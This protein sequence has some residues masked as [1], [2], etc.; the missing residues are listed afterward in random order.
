MSMTE[1]ALRR[2]A[3]TTPSRETSSMRLLASGLHFST[4]P[5]DL[6]KNA[7]STAIEYCCCLPVRTFDGDLASSPSCST[8]RGDSGRTTA[9]AWTPT[10]S[11]VDGPRLLSQSPGTTVST[12]TT[13]VTAYLHNS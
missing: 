9:V 4:Q 3:K 6:T 8:S 10:C 12:A 1:T 13:R 7:G 5:I 2:P 11:C